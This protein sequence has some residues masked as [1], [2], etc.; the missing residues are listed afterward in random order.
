MLCI[1][2]TFLKG[3]LDGKST[4]EFAKSDHV[5]PSSNGVCTII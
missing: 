5:V 3:R 4:Q 1:Y 2:K